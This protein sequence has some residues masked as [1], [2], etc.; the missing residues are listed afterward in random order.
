MNTIKRLLCLM[1][2]LVIG[3]ACFAGCNERPDPSDKDESKTES[4]D[5]STEESTDDSDETVPSDLI[6]GLEDYYKFA[7]STL[8]YRILSRSSTTY[9]FESASGLE[10]SAVEA[11]VFARNEEVMERCGVEITVEPIAGDWSSRETYMAA[12]RNNG[13][14]SVG[15]YE[16]LATHSVYLMNLAVE[17]LAWDFNDLPNLDLTKRWWSEA[18]YEKSN[19]NGAQY[20]AVGDIAYTLYSYMLVVFFNAQMATDLNIDEDLYDLALDGDWTFAKL[21]EYTAKAT[22]NPD[23][24]FESREFGF[25]ANGHSV[26]NMMTGF[27]FELIP[28]N[29]EGK[30]EIKIL[31]PAEL[32]APYQ[33]LADFILETPQIYYST[34]GENGSGDQNEIFAS[35]R[36]LFYTQ[37]LGQATYF[38]GTMRDE[39]GLLPLPK[40]TDTQKNY[41]TGY[42]DTM[43][44]VMVPFNVGQVEM[45]GTVTEMLSEV[46]Y[47]EVTNEYYEETLKYQSFNNPKCVATLEMIRKSVDPSFALIYANCLGTCDSLLS[48]LIENN[49]KNGSNGSVSSYYMNNSGTWRS[50]LKDLYEDLDMIAQS[51]AAS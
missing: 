12:V 42:R 49:I 27:E 30:R 40:Y 13:K 16:L 2:V 19:Y 1:L 14:L 21:K 47:W 51:R 9:E 7:D 50:L 23:T 10:G 39:Y 5:E 28:L 22:T 36:A 45:V 48:N 44:A 4:S 24:P 35:G 37:M 8:P 41:H 20:I 46:S 38:K 32:E 33:A 3:L 25:L 18:F 17:G 43:T 11:A 6:S 26:R 15:E 29:T 34:N 31:M